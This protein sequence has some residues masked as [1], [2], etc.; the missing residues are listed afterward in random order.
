[1][2]TSLTYV[3]VGVVAIT[4]LLAI[5]Y[6]LS[7]PR[8]QAYDWSQHREQVVAVGVIGLALT[9]I[10]WLCSTVGWN[11]WNNVWTN[12]KSLF[13]I[14]QLSIVFACI[15]FISLENSIAKLFSRGLLL[16][17]TL[18]WF[19]VNDFSIGDLIPDPAQQTIVKKTLVK[20]GEVK[21]F[22]HS[23]IVELDDLPLIH[24]R[25][26]NRGE[27][28]VRK[29]GQDWKELL[30]ADTN[31]LEFKADRDFIVKERVPR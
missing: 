31:R 5:G 10:N 18:G 22:Y 13:W 16:L 6:F 29:F 27:F 25:V 30:P 15:V 23:D 4:V 24:Y 3:I 26:N 17:C 9:L 12:H 14:T 11:W 8:D 1:M 2:N 20:A 7:R 19:T 21:G 28:K